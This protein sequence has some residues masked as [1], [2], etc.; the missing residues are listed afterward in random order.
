M[1]KPKLP[2]RPKQSASIATLEN[3]IKS[4]RAT[5]KKYKDQ[6]A[7]AKKV[8]AEKKAIAAKR[9]SLNDA[10]TKERAAYARMK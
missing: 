4:I 1:S 3:H 5:E 9:K 2:K 8:V 7:A 6:L 10:I